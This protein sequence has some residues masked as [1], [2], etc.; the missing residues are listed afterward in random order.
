MTTALPISNESMARAILHRTL[1]ESPEQQ[2][3]AL[4]RADARYAPTRQR[5]GPMFR[6][7]VGFMDDCLAGKVLAR[8]VAGKGKGARA[9]WVFWEVLGD[10]PRPVISV[11]KL[12]G[13]HYRIEEAELVRVSQHALQRLFQRLRTTDP[14]VALLEVLPAA[15]SAVELYAKAQANGE[16]YAAHLRV[17]TGE[18]EAVLVWPTPNTDHGPTARRLPSALEYRSCLVIDE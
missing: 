15:S 14:S 8:S 11:A 10:S 2:R 18:G 5:R 6:A 12:D 17:P 4:E 13:R 1:R 16:R 7:G 9:D 3:R